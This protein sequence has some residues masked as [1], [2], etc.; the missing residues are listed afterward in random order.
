MWDK[1]T[2]GHVYPACNDPER[3]AGAALEPGSPP[4]DL[5]I[6]GL[7]CLFLVWDGYQMLQ[8]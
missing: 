5:L 1:Y 2:A 3:L 4:V 8:M 6:L 7:P